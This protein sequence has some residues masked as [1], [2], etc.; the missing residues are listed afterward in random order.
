MSGWLGRS[1]VDLDTIGS[2]N[3]EALARARA[4]APHGTAVTARAQTQGRGR[5]GRA[6]H[7]PPG[8]NV[9]LS[10]ILRLPIAPAAA[11][12]LTLAVGVA[13]CETVRRLA[14]RASLKW[15]NDV[16]IEGKKVAGILT[17]TSTRGAELDAVIVGIGVNVAT[18]SFPPELAVL[19]TSLTIAAGHPIA[20]ADVVDALLAE[21]ELWIDRFV[22]EGPGPIA[23]AARERGAQLDAAAEALAERDR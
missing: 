3:D 21:A 18:T 2:T 14:G 23:R 1:R 7:S 20:T 16:L 19:A 9:Y 6:W 5:Q 10:I 11:P 13:V 15:P 17:E 12:P 22:A 8:E 4:G